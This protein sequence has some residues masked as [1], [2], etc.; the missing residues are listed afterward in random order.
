MSSLG[1]EQV[2]L[3]CTIAAP[4][5]ATDGISRVSQLVS[6]T[7][8]GLY[9]DDIRI[10]RLFAAGR[11]G[12]AAAPAKFRFAASASAMQL[13]R[14]ARWVLFDHINIARIQTVL[15]RLLRAPYAV[16]LHG[17][18][19]WRPLNRTETRTLANAR[20][21]IA[22]SQY[23]AAR[24]A[25]TSGASFPVEVCH[26]ALVPPASELSDA[27]ASPLLHRMREPAVLMV[28]RMD[29]RERYKGH[30]EVIRAW[31]QVVRAVPS[32]Q[33]VIVGSGD[34]V[35]R[36]QK[37]AGPLCESS[38][39]FCGQVSETTLHAIYRRAHVFCLPSRGEGF[40][41]VYLEA[42]HHGLPCIAARDTAAAEIIVNNET[43]YLVD[44]NDPGAI[45]RRI[46]ELLTDERLRSRLGS[47]AYARVSEVF[48][49]DRYKEHLGDILFRHG[50]H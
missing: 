26:L 10:L 28:G 13:G 44:P 27:A 16:F 14:A 23:T 38:V 25:E 22:N 33:L 46:V 4:G 8:R 21:L 35:A 12:S 49:F 11:N 2:G 40:G 36:L 37:L 9:G 45:A 17:I 32:A 24:F 18:E 3:F 39:L 30:E 20:V 41:L 1:H 15:P 19:V 47:A 48:S 5:Q 43:G 42:M 7:I 31:P 29:S 34:D 6:A 50:F